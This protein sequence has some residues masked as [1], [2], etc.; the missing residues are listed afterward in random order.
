VLSHHGHESS[1]GSD[2]RSPR[3]REDIIDRAPRDLANKHSYAVFAGTMDPSALI[4]A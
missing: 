3:G 2:L 4:D 1:V